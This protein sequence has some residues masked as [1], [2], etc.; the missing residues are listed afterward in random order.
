MCAATQSEP[1]QMAYARAMRPNHWTKNAIVLAAFFFA[2]W[3][4]ERRFPVTLSDLG[5][6]IPAALLFCI[7]SS[8]I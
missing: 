6:V 4:T 3:D 7:V 1:L 5:V 2:F 8:G